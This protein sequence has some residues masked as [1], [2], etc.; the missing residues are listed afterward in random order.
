MAL[1]SSTTTAHALCQSAPWSIQ[2]HNMSATSTV[3]SQTLPTCSAR[4]KPT[5]MAVSCLSLC[6][7]IQ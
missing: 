5:G 7:S 1:T 6:R 3:S 4:A 2:N